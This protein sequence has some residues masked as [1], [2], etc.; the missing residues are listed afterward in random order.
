MLENLKIGSRL[1]IGFIAMIAILILLTLYGIRSMDILSQQTTMMYNHPL[2]VSNA[3]LRIN[4]NIIKI[5]RSMKDVVLSKDSESIYENARIVDSLER[6]VFSDFEIIGERYLGE[7]KEYA[8]ALEIFSGWKPVRDEVISLMLEGER[9]KAADIT[10]EEGADHVE[11]IEMAMEA[12]GK[13]A[14]YK[15]EDFLDSVKN[16][17]S[18]AFNMMYLFV[19]LAVFT[20]VLLALFITRS[21]TYPIGILKR[22]TEKIGRGQLDTTI[23]ITS[24]DEIGQLAASI[25]KMA[26]DLADI[27]RSRNDRT[28]ELESAVELLND[29]VNEHRK[30]RNALRESEE[31]FRTLVEQSPVSI[32]IMDPDG[33]TIQVNRAWQKLWGLTLSDLADYNMLKD[34]QL[35]Q[36]GIMSYIKKAFSGEPAFIPAAEYDAHKTLSKGEKRWVQA[37]VYPVKG[38][39]GDIRMVVLTHEDITERKLAEDKVSASLREKEVLLKEIHHRVK[40]NMAVISS[41]LKLQANRVKD[42]RAREMFIDSIGR[43]Q[44][45]AMIHEKLYRAEDLAR[46]DFRAYMKEMIASMFTSYRLSPGKI[47][48]HMDIENVS[49]SIDDAIPFGL[50]INELLS[51]CLKYAFPEDRKGNIRVELYENDDNEIELTVSDDG[52]GMPEWLDLENADSLGLSLVNALTTQLQGRIE[53]NRENGTAFKISFMRH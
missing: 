49:M 27:T 13:F 19:G 3:V 22:A 14:Q 50:I 17:R 32:Q 52:V 33:R 7:K 35:E 23:N 6:K 46:V 4:A 44:S 28:A 43:I 36:L 26:E 40:N 42:D 11:R 2:T 53:L 29:E 10:R 20:A 30:A 39:S 38:E 41:L 1:A 18:N 12:L 9:E 5:H 21:C 37:R 25:N 8:F 51:N 15:A 24:K 45:M 47:A 31:Q 48:L 34:R 16:T